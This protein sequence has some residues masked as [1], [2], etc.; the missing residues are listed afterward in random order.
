MQVVSC[1]KALSLSVATQTRKSTNG[2]HVV[3]E[4]ELCA[5][6]GNGA[7]DLQ[8]ESCLCWKS[9]LLCVECTGKQHENSFALQ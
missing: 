2:L 3:S 7:S 6:L 5:G 9:I 1:M 8:Y 4:R